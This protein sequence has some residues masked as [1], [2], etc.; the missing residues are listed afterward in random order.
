MRILIANKFYY[1]RGGDCIYTFELE[2]LLKKNGHDVA[3]FAQ[4]HPNNYK[5]QYSNY[6][7]SEVNYSSINITNIRE[8]LIRPVFSKEIN[9]KYNELINYFK[10]DVVHLNNIHT[11]LSPLIAEISYNN[12]NSLSS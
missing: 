6:W 12:D 4:N 10:P 3:I 7:P 11:Q 2:K 5:N 9:N 8:S 1:P